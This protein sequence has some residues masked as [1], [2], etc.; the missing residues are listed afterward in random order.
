MIFVNTRP[1]E[2]ALALS[3]YLKQPNITQMLGAPLTVVDMPL[4][5]IEP[6]SLS[7]SSLHKLNHL[8]DYRVLVVVSVNAWQYAK[9]FVD[10]AR[11]AVLSRQGL[12]VIA[13]GD[14]TARAL[15]E[16]DVCCQLPMLASNEGMLAMSAIKHL[17]K[18]DKVMIWRGVGGRRLLHDVLQARDI[19][20]DG[21]AFYER[22]KPKV[23]DV[24]PLYADDVAQTDIVVLITSQQAFEH[25]CDSAQD[26]LTCVTYIALG[27]RLTKLIHDRLLPMR[28]DLRV[29]RVE[30]LAP[31]SIAQAIL[32]IQHQ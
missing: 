4:L 20:V 18:T 11:L 1:H 21:I 27:A 9:R 3:A 8:P 10:V 28:H 6:I 30:S 31:D 29:L 25:W 5:N 14:A 17:G 19:V 26:L 16:C 15:G 2:Q 32:T 22:T 24:Q 7:E 13:V 12:T 23:L